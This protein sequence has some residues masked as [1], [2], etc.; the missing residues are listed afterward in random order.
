MECALHGRGRQRT[1]LACTTVLLVAVCFACTSPGERPEY[2]APAVEFQADEAAFAASW[3]GGGPPRLWTREL[4]PGY[5]GIVAGADRVYT[6]FRNDLDEVVVGLDARTGE[7]VWEYRYEAPPARGHDSDY[8]DGPNA[9]PLLADGRL[10]SIGVAGILHCLDA[11]TGEKL[12]SRDLWGDLGGNVLE[13]GYSSS[14]IVYEDVV[15]VLVGTKDH[16]IVALDPESGSVVWSNLSFENSYSTPRI[17]NI[18]GEDQLVACMARE[19]IGVD[20]HGGALLW[21]YPIVNQWEQN[22]ARPMLIDDDLLF[23]STLEAGSRGLKLVPGAAFDV[24]EVWS[25]R[26]MQL[27]YTDA[28]LIGDLIYGSSGYS[29][30]PLMTAIRAETGELAWRVRGFSVASLIGVRN[31]LVILDEEGKLALATPTPDGLTVHAEAQVSTHPSRTAPTLSGTI[32]YVRDFRNIT[33][34]DLGK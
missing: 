29:A 8:G 18:H 12:W 13:L 5:S 20:L 11:D 26:R 9:R 23:I 15:I 1:T 14:P 10:Y 32:L 16:S 31:R 24:Q 19:V 33:A 17:I 34:L 2:G 6:M 3:P 30:A 28:V 21:R 22:I 27:F 7:T 25:T 4:G